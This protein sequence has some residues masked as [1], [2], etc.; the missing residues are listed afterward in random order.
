MRFVPSLEC[1]Q[2]YNLYGGA[3][4]GRMYRNAPRS[5]NGGNEYY[6]E[7]ST[8]P[9]GYRASMQKKNG[10]DLSGDFSPGLLDLQ[11]FDTE[12]LPPEV[13]I[14]LN[15]RTFIW[16]LC[17]FVLKLLFNP[18][19]NGHIASVICWKITATEIFNFFESLT[20]ES[21]ILCRIFV[22]VVENCMLGLCVF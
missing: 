22:D 5:F 10:E 17:F 13:V 4:G 21:V 19:N 11:S 1:E 15:G 20:L 9:G 18:V 14:F 2:D 7:P 16:F 6:M 8:P 3:Q 12:L